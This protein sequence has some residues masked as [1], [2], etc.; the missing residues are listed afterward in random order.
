MATTRH[1]RASGATLSEYSRRLAEADAL[2]QRAEAGLRDARALRDQSIREAVAAGLSLR[3]VGAQLGLSAQ[4]VSAAL[5][6]KR[7]LYDDIGKG[8][9]G[10]RQPDPRIQRLIWAALAG[11]KTVVNVGAGAGSY[12]PPETLLAVEPSLVMVAQRP[13]GLA[14]AAV[15]TADRIPLPGNA[16]DAV[17]GVLT[18]HHW[19]NL[20]AGIAEVRRVARRAV[21]LTWDFEVSQHFWLTRYVPAIN[22]LDRRIAV[23]IPRLCE[24]LETR[25]VRVVPVP[26]DCV[27]GFLGAYWRRPEAYLDPAV[28]AGI[29]SLARLD[30]SVVQAGME[31]LLEDLRSGEWERRHAQLLSL[32]EFDIG[33][34]L[35]VGEWR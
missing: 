35:V 18:L 12:E 23:A 20:E 17:L 26:H 22:D 9:A 6:Q 19:D 25:D 34:R 27:D 13:T 8:Y 14:P 3:Q 7:A 30:Q 16:V 11:A 5:S 15:T 21:F 33:Y 29:S 2:L 28:R 24:L 10:T 32:D 4:G 31:L 1:D